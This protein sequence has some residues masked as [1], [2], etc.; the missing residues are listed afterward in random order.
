MKDTLNAIPEV[1]TQ[2]RSNVHKIIEEMLEN[3]DG[4]GIYPTGQAYDKLE[5][6]LKEV[7]IE[8]V[9]WTWAEAYIQLDNHQDSREYNMDLLIEKVNKDLNPLYKPDNENKE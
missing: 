9:G 6:L 8:A 4:C 1:I 5:Q 3:P 7:R 2:D